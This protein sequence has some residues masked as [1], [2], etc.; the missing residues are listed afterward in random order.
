MALSNGTEREYEP[1]RAGRETGLVGVERAIAL[2]LLPFLP[3]SVVK[4]ALGV[5]LLAAL[6]GSRRG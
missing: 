4:V 6:R 1:D 3:G 5:T 2:G